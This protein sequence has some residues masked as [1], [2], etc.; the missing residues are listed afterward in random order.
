MASNLHV[1][2]IPKTKDQNAL[3]CYADAINQYYA[4]QKERPLTPEETVIYKH[5]LE[6]LRSRMTNTL[7]KVQAKYSTRKR[8]ETPDIFSSNDLRDS[9]SKCGS[10]LG[11]IHSEFGSNGANSTTGTDLESV[12]ISRSTTDIKI[13]DTPEDYIGS[14]N[15][16]SSI[17]TTEA[18]SSNTSR[19]S[20][21]SGLVK[22]QT[23]DMMLI[24][25][26]SSVEL[27]ARQN[28]RSLDL[29]HA[30]IATALESLNKTEWERLKT[31]FSLP[32]HIIEEA[33]RYREKQSIKS[34][35][36]S[37]SSRP[38]GV[39][40]RKS[41]TMSK[42]AKKVIKGTPPTSSMKEESPENNTF[43]QCYSKAKTNQVSVVVT[44][45][46]RN[47]EEYQMPIDN[48]TNEAID[49]PSQSNDLPG[50]S[51]F[52]ESMLMSPLKQGS[53]SFQCI[54]QGLD[55]K[56]I[57]ISTQRFLIAV[58]TTDKICVWKFASN[59][60]NKYGYLWDEV[61][62]YSF[63]NYRTVLRTLLFTRNDGFLIVTEIV[64]TL[65]LNEVDNYFLR[66][67]TI[68]LDLETHTAVNL[69]ISPSSLANI[70]DLKELPVA[71][72]NHESKL[73]IPSG[74]FGELIVYYFEEDWSTLI[75]DIPLPKSEI[76]TS[77]IVSLK[78]VE[79]E[80]S[81]AIGTSINSVTLWNIDK[82][83]LLYSAPF[84]DDIDFQSIPKCISAVSPIKYVRM[85]AMART[86]HEPIVIILV[87]DM[88]YEEDSAD[89]T[90]VE[91]CQQ[92]L[93]Y[94][95]QLSH[96]ASLENFSSITSLS[97]SQKCVVGC[98]NDTD[99]VLW[100]KSNGRIISTLQLVQQHRVNR[101]V[102]CISIHHQDM[103]IIC[104]DTE[105]CLHIY[106]L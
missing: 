2:P 17:I 21:L 70:L 45:R 94:R 66:I 48:S 75:S 37:S 23:K 41:L 52:A 29:K 32:K 102:Y 51:S 69:P 103:Y 76:A 67:T 50:S 83:T 18:D 90:R 57:V 31:P 40:K 95:S 82:C 84:P 88:C 46:K 49:S 39:R 44:P 1:K 28:K 35:A 101:R 93:L 79:N 80:P 64:S 9:P 65:G 10:F 8:E 20:S 38:K 72:P 42:S 97:T 62:T 61:F 16:Q 30:L 33:N 87:A 24:T 106:W 60:S 53:A 89:G 58:D 19:H 59:K 74:M 86:I 68:N 25:T 5:I 7:E 96:L 34:K 55:V 12:T 91:S 71:I 56:Q 14:L 47:A 105:G 3:T 13:E 36:S 15:K 77:P 98:V 92:Y 99:V 54:S 6:K 78:L 81:L 104:G 63:P 43:V 85:K 22:H 27:R 73:I 11:S 4:I 26:P 100:N